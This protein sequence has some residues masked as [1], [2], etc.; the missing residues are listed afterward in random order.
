MLGGVGAQRCTNGRAN[1]AL[2][3]L[4]SIVEVSHYDQTPAVSVPKASGHESIQPRIDTHTSHKLALRISAPSPNEGTWLGRLRVP[5]RLFGALVFFVRVPLVLAADAGDEF[6][7]N[8]FS[9]LAPLLALFGE[10]FTKQFMSQSMNWEESVIFA[11]APL[12]IITAITSA[13]RA[14]GPTWMKAIIG[15]AREG[16]GFIEM[17]LMSSTSHD[18]SEVWD[19]DA[20][21]R[22]LGSPQ[23]IELF[24]SKPTEIK[25]TSLDKT[26][27][28]SGNGERASLL[29]PNDRETRHP[30]EIYDFQTAISAGILSSNTNRPPETR[31]MEGATPNIALNISD[32][33]VSRLEMKAVAMV[34]VLLQSGVLIFAGFSV[35]Y[36]PWNVKFD[37][38][39][40]SVKP[41]AFPLVCTGT[42]TLVLGMF[43]CSLIVERSTDEEKWDINEGKKFQVV[44]LQKGCSVGDQHFGS[45]LIQRKNQASHKIITSHRAEKRLDI[46]TFVGS[47]L[48]LVGWILQFFGLRGL[49]WSVT[50]AQLVAT[51]VMTILRAVLRRGLVYDIRSTPIEDG[52]ELDT[53]AREITGCGAWSV[54]TWGFDPSC[55]LRERRLAERVLDA[56]C[57]LGAISKWGHQWQAA[58][59]AT[60]EAIEATVNGLCANPDVTTTGLTNVFKWELIVEVTSG[61]DPTSTGHIAG[62]FPTNDATPIAVGASAADNVP[63]ADRT[64]IAD[65]TLAVSPIAPNQKTLEVINLS[66]SRKWLSDGRGWSTWKVDKSQV[67]AVLGQWML[68][69]GP[70]GGMR[71]GAKRCRVIGIDSPSMRTS[72]EQWVLREAEIINIPGSGQTARISGSTSSSERLIFIGE[73]SPIRSLFVESGFLAVISEAPLENICGQAIL[74]AFMT[75]FV[76]TSLESIGGGVR[77]RGGERGVKASFGLRSGVLDELAEKVERTG[78]AS[79]EDALSCIVPPLQNSGKLPLAGVTSTDVFSDTVQEITNYFTGG[80]LELAEPLLIWLL[81]VAESTIGSYVTS[82]EW[83][84]ASKIYILLCNTYDSIQGGEDYS[85]IAGKEMGLFCELWAIHKS[86]SGVNADDPFT[87]IIDALGEGKDLKMWK[88]RLKKWSE[89]DRLRIGDTEANSYTNTNAILHEHELRQAAAKGDCL[90]VAR[91]VK[92]EPNSINAIDSLGRTPL[93]L[94]ACAGYA[95]VVALLL[96][97]GADH[98]IGDHRG[99]TPLHYASMRGHTS[100]IRALL[101]R[102]Q[103]SDTINAQDQDSKSPLDYALENNHGSGAAL[104]IFHGAH[105]PNDSGTTSLA[106]S[107]KHGSPE[108]IRAM[109]RAGKD[110]GAE[111]PESGLT[112]LHWSVWRDSQTGLGLLLEANANP[113]TT[114]KVGDTPLHYAARKGRVTMVELLLRQKV[115]VNARGQDGRTALYL[116]MQ[117]GHHRVACMLLDHGADTEA[118]KEDGITAM[119]LSAREGHADI[120]KQ[121]LDRGDDIETKKKDGKTA[122]HLAAKVGDEAVVGL[123]LDRGANIEAKSG[124]GMTALHFAAN[125]GDD[126][127]VRFLLDRGADI[128][129]KTD[130]G[131]TAL[132]TAVNGG[133]GA[134]ARLLLDRDADVE[135][136]T[137]SGMTALHLAAKEGNDATVSF[138]LDRGADVT[139]KTDSG[140]TALHTAANGGHEATARLLLDRGANLE[141]KSGS[142]MTALHFAAKEGNDATVSFL[143]VRGADIMAKTDS[144]DTEIG[145][146]HV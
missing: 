18:V 134:T 96:G 128:M 78:L 9:D 94:A 67:A 118:G 55:V 130:S 83:G 32:R 89:N 40:E 139:V 41:Y 125:E 100:V 129:A 71:H 126:A 116:A 6:S 33:R 140:D 117:R 91:L 22:V 79:I 43:F 97:A 136:K 2:P 88:G 26:G 60:A 108:A 110:I 104:L 74:S 15:R 14:G 51:A 82:G 87:T 101:R 106:L 39:G 49:N 38:D 27:K 12:G 143:L 42:A 119:L 112:P 114:D 133:H 103:A 64:P 109:L 70:Q 72:Y 86:A 53:I 105:D 131:D 77:G 84:Q 121:C 93:V 123:L 127:T 1:N 19:G 23:I 28:E 107:L 4:R 3:S 21:V 69:F 65:E 24:Y 48:S 54:V 98:I 50:I 66:M 90:S 111:D 120:V 30:T 81:D 37:K 137:G 61:G 68:H 13:I 46:L 47:T 20:V 76:Q 56:R 75:S 63:P 102:A 8:L 122:L 44:W 35:L 138:L 145:R 58:V 17:E 5:S 141:A 25:A 57:R 34:G 31:N 99:R 142:G 80:R 16:K 52:Y 11:M 45:Y 144:G 113:D 36:W 29:L 95:T 62:D 73:P 10:Q 59:D 92:R 85:E 115:K 132:H 7:N 124:S 135:A 146:A